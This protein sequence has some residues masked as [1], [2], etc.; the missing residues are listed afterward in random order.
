MQCVHLSTYRKPY[1]A[2]VKKAVCSR[3]VIPV[4]RKSPSL[5]CKEVQFLRRLSL[6]SLASSGIRDLKDNHNSSL[7]YGRTDW[8]WPHRSTI[9][10]NFG[11]S[12]FTSKPILRA[13]EPKHLKP[14]LFGTLRNW[15]STQLRRAQKAVYL[16]PI[17]LHLELREVV[18]GKPI[19]FDP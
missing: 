2:M 9:A 18:R 16:H 7:K 19:M 10:W 1:E 4:I 15:R 3:W 14:N 8:G 12:G 17:N 13:C 6:N 11:T 5:A